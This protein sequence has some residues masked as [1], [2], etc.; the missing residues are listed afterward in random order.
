MI[1]VD[2]GLPWNKAVKLAKQCWGSVTFWYG[3]RF[4]PLTNGSGYGSEM[5]KNIWILQ[6][7]IRTTGKSHKEVTKQKKSRFSLLFLLENGRIWSR[8]CD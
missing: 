3:S 7:L 8:T 5:P 4:V 1:N 6:I 2:N